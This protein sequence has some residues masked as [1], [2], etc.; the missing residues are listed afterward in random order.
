MLEVVGGGLV[1]VV[2]AVV[3]VEALV[4]LFVSS[5]ARF[6]KRSL[7]MRRS[8]VI[9]RS[10]LRRGVVAGVDVAI[11]GA[12]AFARVGVD[13]MGLV[14]LVSAVEVVG[15]ALVLVGVG[16]GSG[17]LILVAVDVIVEVVVVCVSS[18]LS[19]VVIAV[20]S[21]VVID[22]GV[23]GVVIVV[24]VRFEVVGDM[25]VDGVVK[26]GVVV[27]ILVVVLSVFG[28]VGVNVGADADRVGMG[29]VGD[30]LV[31]VC[32]GLFGMFA[33]PSQCASAP[34]PY[35]LPT[36]AAVSAVG[37]AAVAI[38]AL[39][40]IGVDHLCGVLLVA[41]LVC[42]F[43][44]QCLFMHSCIASISP[45]CADIFFH[46]ALFCARVDMSSKVRWSG[47]SIKNPPSDP[48][49]NCILTDSLTSLSPGSLSRWPSHLKRL[50]LIARTRS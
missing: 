48:R 4:L 22:I 37:V 26:V 35:H 15:A 38:A 43:V 8:C 2:S 7:L 24:V 32:G 11:A 17:D 20:K 30:L 25:V 29:V 33:G 39:D 36:V 49:W 28:V 45:T 46:V 6:L 18:S 23:V 12:G 47:R 19:P 1:W 10:R 42:A 41:S 40:A 27:V 44:G 50:H 16:T 3:V 9:C 13:V 31:G 34:C 21:A 5:R 14:C